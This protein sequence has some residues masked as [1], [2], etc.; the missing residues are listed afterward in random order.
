M[1]HHFRRRTFC[2]DASQNQGDNPVADAGHEPD[3]VLDQQNGEPPA[4]GQ[5]PDQLRQFLALLIV[6]SRGWFIEKDRA[7][8]PG[9]PSGDG[10]NRADLEIRSC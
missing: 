10:R 1:S 2:D 3:V 9:K 5:M 7:G 8:I 4:T 6:E